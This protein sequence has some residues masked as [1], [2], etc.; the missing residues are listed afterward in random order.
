M[1][2]GFERRRIA[3]GDSELHVVLG[4]D[5]PPLLLLHGFPQTHAAWHA[6]AP[7]LAKRFRLVIPDLP[8]YGESKG[9]ASDPAHVNYSKRVMGQTM[10][11]LMA[12]LDHQR[13]MLAGHD[14]GGR[15]AYRMA[16][17]HPDRVSRFAAVDIIPT[18]TAWERMDW[19]RALD[20][21]HWLFLAQPAPLP[22][23]MIGRDPDFYVQHLLDR[24]AGRPKSL[25][26]EAVAEYVRRFRKPSVIAASCADY[27]AGA[28]VDVEH[29]RADRE[30]GRRIRCP[31]LILW[32]RGFL[33]KKTGSPLAVWREWADQVSEVALDCGH[34]VV[35]EQPDA[36]AMAL[37]EFFA[38]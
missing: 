18:L 6:V 11:E 27:R 25:H 3:V 33:S 36:A 17:D 24:W 21:Y 15:V 23:H 5:G 20:G 37:E 1:F 35:E 30:A 14:R 29:D 4:G 8:G 19:S 34:F 9:P 16:L 38:G 10:V 28:T 31:V 12:A 22:E 7:R 26:P 32:G 13:F 2:D